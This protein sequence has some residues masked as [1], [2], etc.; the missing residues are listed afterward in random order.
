MKA[1][2]IARY[3]QDHPKFFEEYADLCAALPP[4]SACGVL[5]ITDCRT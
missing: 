4:A 5:S 1:D 3:L 2:E